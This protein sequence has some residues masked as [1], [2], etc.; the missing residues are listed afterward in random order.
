M[1]N[2]RALTDPPLDEVQPRGTRRRTVQMQ[3]WMSRQPLLDMGVVVRPVIVQD[4]VEGL[5]W[6]RVSVDD[7]QERQPLLVAMARIIGAAH[8]AVE[9]RERREQAGGAVGLVGMRL[10][11]ASPRLPRHARVCPI[12]RVDMGFSSRPTTSV[13][14]S[15]HRVSFD[16]LNVSIRC[17]CWLGG[18]TAE[19]SISLIEERGRRVART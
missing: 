19:L 12:H 8:G 5:P 11:A 1:P 4:R 15:T 10:G 9:H 18:K 13:N 6:R 3:S 7:V 16:R 14:V 2:A 17:G